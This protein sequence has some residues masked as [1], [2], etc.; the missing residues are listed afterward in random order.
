[1]TRAAASSSP[2]LTGASI[3]DVSPM[4]SGSTAAALTLALLRCPT[5]CRLPPSVSFKPLFP[6]RFPDFVFRRRTP[7]LPVSPFLLCPLPV[8]S[9]FLKTF[10]LLVHFACPFRAGRF[11]HGSLSRRTPCPVPAVLQKSVNL[12]VFSVAFSSGGRYNRP[13]LCTMRLKGCDLWSGTARL[14]FP[15]PSYSPQV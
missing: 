11:L 13:E 8:F 15:L 2:S 9:H 6:D 3:Q 12:A 1:M 7:F 4:C 10:S 14:S 5:R